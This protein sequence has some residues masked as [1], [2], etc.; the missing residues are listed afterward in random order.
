MTNYTYENWYQSTTGDR[1][2]YGYE[3]LIASNIGAA[4]LVCFVQEEGYEG[5]WSCFISDGKRIGLVEGYFGSCGGCDALEDASASEA[6]ELA[7]DYL[8]SVRTF[9]SW[10]EVR[11]YF[12]ECRKERRWSFHSDIGEL[13]KFA[14]LDLPLGAVDIF[15]RLQ[16]DDPNADTGT[17]V[18]AAKLLHV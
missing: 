15:A 1:Y 3:S 16:N 11:V 6:L 18:E 5:S 9:S 10:E 4:A 8:K 14:Q 12:G 2:R 17:L 7:E 13:E